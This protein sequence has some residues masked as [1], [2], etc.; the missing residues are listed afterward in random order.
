MPSAF[1][2]P[3]TVTGLTQKEAEDRLRREGPNDLPSP[4]KHSWLALIGEVMREP[5]FALL[6]GSAGLYAVI[7]DL[8]EA[9]VLAAFATVSVSIALVQR[10][11]SEKVLQAL[12]DLS[13]PRALVIRDGQARRIPGREVVRGDVIVVTEGDR[14]PADAVLKEGTDIRVDES[15]LTGES[16]PVSKREAASVETAP[17]HSPG[18]E[19]LPYL[20][21]GTLMLS[22]TGVG[23][24]TA[25]G[26]RSEIGKIGTT[27]R[28]IEAEQPRL[29]AQT[30]HIVLVFAGVGFLFS[31]GAVL[32]YGVV[33]GNWLEGVLA[34]IALGM[35]MLPEEFP[36]VLAVFMVMGAWRLSRSRVLTRR[37]AAIE[38]L[39]S[40]TV[41]CTDKTGTLTQNLMSVAAA[42]V[43][44]GAD[45]D[46]EKPFSALAGSPQL[47]SLIDAGALAGEP[48]ALDPMD[49][50]LQRLASESGIAR[51]PVAD[52]VR[53]YP[54]QPGRLAV[55]CVWKK[56]EGQPLVVAAKGA[57]ETI[58]DFCKMGAEERAWLVPIE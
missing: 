38:T 17:P 20:Y 9:A 41:L 4:E 5:M 52:L 39:G 58:A 1:K 19:G 28:G 10:G 35:A 23:V 51:E 34:G 56:A 11:R 29:Q 45:W 42:S 54:L 43:P 22:G 15:L 18:G 32:L 27:V 46:R 7:G 26:A 44:G 24:V 31:L 49:R 16:L 6:L 55:T 36:L 47:A 50:A 13:S 8:G 14:I 30:K 57:P 2:L 37:A 21:S 33:R 48:K 3:E 25:T 40:A 53:L 12:R